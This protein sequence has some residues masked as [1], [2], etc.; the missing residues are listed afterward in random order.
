VHRRFRI[1]GAGA[2][3][4]DDHRP[5]LPLLFVAPTPILGL[6]APLVAS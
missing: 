2:E 4:G 6:T 3:L 1:F 5:A